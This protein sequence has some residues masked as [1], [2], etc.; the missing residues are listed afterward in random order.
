VRCKIDT[1]NATGLSKGYAQYE[2][3]QAAS[4]AIKE[5]DGMLL[6]GQAVTVKMVESSKE[7]NTQQKQNEKPTKIRS[8]KQQNIWSQSHRWSYCPPMPMPPPIPPMIPPLVPENHPASYNLTERSASPGAIK[9]HAMLMRQ[10]WL[11]SPHQQNLLMAMEE[12]LTTPNASKIIVQENIDYAVKCNCKAIIGMI[13][14][15]YRNGKVSK[16]DIEAAMAKVL[17]SINT[18]AHTN[19]HI[20]DNFGDMFCAFCQMQVLN[21]V[22][23]AEC[24]GRLNDYAPKLKIIECAMKSIQKAHGNAAVRSCFSGNEGIALG[25]LLG[26]N[27]FAKLEALFRDDSNTDAHQHRDSS[28]SS[29]SSSESEDDAEQFQYREDISSSSS[30]SEYFW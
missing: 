3:N 17:E 19:P 13:S 12:V 23:L 6:N 11:R 24:T 30:E 29:S 9:A 26:A 7:Y 15:L 20:Y 18:L 22:W 28:S 25:K 2:T 14:V 5:F 10:E 21:A 1:N 16:F 8:D 27:E 4:C